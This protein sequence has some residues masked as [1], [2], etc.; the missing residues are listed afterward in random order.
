MNERVMIVSTLDIEATGLDSVPRSFTATVSGTRRGVGAPSRAMPHVAKKQ[1][2][3]GARMNRLEA[4]CRVKRKM[5]MG[6]G[7]QGM[8]R[9]AQRQA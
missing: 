3:Q 7:A 2:Y 5:Q 6:S 4:E 9:A 8:S 1:P